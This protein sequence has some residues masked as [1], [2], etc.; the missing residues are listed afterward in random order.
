MVR[1]LG[2]FIL[3][4]FQL[5]VFSYEFEQ[6]GES[7]TCKIS[8]QMKMKPVHPDDNTGSA[9]IEVFLREKNGTPL[10]DKQIQLTATAGTFYCRL[11]DKKDSTGT[12][13]SEDQT[14]YTTDQYGKAR[15]NIVNLLAGETVQVKVTC[16]CGGYFVYA[17]GSLAWKATK[18][19]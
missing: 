1:F 13:P 6:P 17:S 4:F 12:D 15:I 5:S 8:L 10:P 3:L 7:S 18:K 19:K 16:D 9:V 14:C 2:L 11:P